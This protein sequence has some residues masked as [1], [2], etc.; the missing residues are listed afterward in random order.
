MELDGYGGTSFVH[1]ECHKSLGNLW[2]S[3]TVSK[4]EKNFLKFHFLKIFEVE[5]LAN[6]LF[7]I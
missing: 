4:F 5:N 3:K 7:I 1:L 6:L 2:D